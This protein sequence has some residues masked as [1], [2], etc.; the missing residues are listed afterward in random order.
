MDFTFAAGAAYV[1]LLL[2]R[3]VTATGTCADATIQ[4]FRDAAR[5]DE[6]YDAENKDPSTQFTDRT[7]A[8]MMGNDGTGLASN[9]MYGR[10]TNND[11]GAATFD[12]EAVL[13]GVV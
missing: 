1:T 5:T 12:V 11:A 6:I 13:W 10:I 3:V 2:L 8:T 4:F 7:P 9:I